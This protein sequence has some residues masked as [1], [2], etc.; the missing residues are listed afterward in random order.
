MTAQSYTF[1]AQ[2]GYCWPKDISKMLIEHAQFLKLFVLHSSVRKYYSTAVQCNSAC[3]SNKAIYPPISKRLE[4]GKDLHVVHV[5]F[6]KDCMFVILGTSI[7]IR[8]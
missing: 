8:W 5:T 3:Y 1:K 2:A 7:F 6:C 4:D